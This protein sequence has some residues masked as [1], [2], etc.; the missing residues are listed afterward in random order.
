MWMIL[1]VGGCYVVHHLQFNNVP[2]DGWFCAL[3]RGTIG[4]HVYFH[5]V[6]HEASKQE[7]IG[8]A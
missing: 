6:K 2:M 3:F 1:A 4:M 8:S 5:T 7:Y